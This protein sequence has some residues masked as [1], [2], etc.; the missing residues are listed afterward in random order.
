[1][2]EFRLAARREFFHYRDRFIYMTLGL[3]IMSRRF[4]DVLVPPRSEK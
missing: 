4:L 1:M 2:F 3:I